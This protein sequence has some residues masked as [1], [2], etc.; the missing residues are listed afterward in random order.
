VA[1]LRSGVPDGWDVE[2]Q[3][4]DGH[5]LQS[6]AWQHVQEALGYEVVGA[7]GDSWLW[8]GSIR[9]GRFPRYLYVPYGPTG[10]D[11]DG[12]LNSVGEV[13][14]SHSLDFARVEPLT[15]PSRE[16][17]TRMSARA[18]ATVQP[19]WTWVLDLTQ[20]EHHL[21]RGLAAGHRGSINAAPRRGLTIR[22]GDDRSDADAFIELQ[23]HAAGRSGFRGQQAQYYLTLLDVLR[24]QQFASLYVAEAGSRVVAA[25]ICFDFAATRYYAHAASDPVEGRRLGAAAPLV[26]QMILD[27]RAD[28]KR[29]FD[30]W[31]VAP[32]GAADHRWA[33]FT[34]FKRAFGGRLVERPGTWELPVHPA[35][36]RLF[37]IVRALRR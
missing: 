21:R 5:F 3:R 35:R 25:A 19:R 36:H 32:P 18:V 7:H 30:F 29:E 8:A 37:T 27:A 2:L 33:G 20:D 10:T 6:R 13:S 1:A 11:M 26:W 14:R 12:A 15:A 31:G 22:R 16:S 9:A 28:G 24:P 17:L 34:Q 23:R 4:L